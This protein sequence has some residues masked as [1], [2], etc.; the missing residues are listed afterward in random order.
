MEGWNS[1]AI[2]TENHKTPAQLFTTGTIV[3]N[4]PYI[5]VADVPGSPEHMNDFSELTPGVVVP[6]IQNPLNSH[7]V[8]TLSANLQLDDS[9][10]DYG[11]DTYNQVRQ[12]IH[13][14]CVS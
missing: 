10:E 2:T 5:P 7:Q 9:M 14:N 1:H 6:E 13:D 8:T 4:E 12:Y 3:R 11:I